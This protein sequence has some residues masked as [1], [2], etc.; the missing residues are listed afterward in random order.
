M[1]VLVTGAT[2]FIGRHLVKELLHHKKYT[3][4]CFVRNPKKAKKLVKLGAQLIFGDITDNQSLE[5]VKGYQMDIIFHCAAYV[6]DNNLRKLHKVNV[7]GT[8]NIC[9]LCL[10]QGVGCLVYLSSVA[11][12][13]GNQQ[14][15][16][17]EDLPFSA[18]N[19]YGQSKIEAEKIVL[20]FRNKGL[21]VIIIRPPMVYGEDEP[22]MFKFLL[23]LLKLRL[24]P[25]INKG[26]N[27]LHLAY[28]EN[29]VE[30]VLFSL[31]KKEFLEG[32]FFVADNEVLKIKD[33][34]TTLSQA[35]GA[36]PPLQL[37]RFIEALILHLPGLSKKLNFFLKDR[38]YSLERIKS[39]GF[40]PHHPAKKSLI[41]SAR[42]LYHGQN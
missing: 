1:N 29:V 7:E 15:P 36:K 19:A 4:F 33:I 42:K 38:V 3:V 12:V 37:P 30:A 23:K 8:K 6:E 27:K 20:D 17:K 18:T 14:L 22:H 11:V 26:E 41:S 2:G 13:S 40:K 35:I 31:E 28:V 24:L 9:K 5:T 34:F 16:L 10:E 21:A 39:L 32:S 25:L